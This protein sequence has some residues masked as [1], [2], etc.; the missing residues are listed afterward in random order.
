MFSSEELHSVAFL[1]GVG[2]AEKRFVSQPVGALLRPAWH[3][4]A[5]A[6]ATAIQVGG[7]SQYQDSVC[8]D[9]DIA[10]HDGPFSTSNSEDLVVYATLTE[11]AECPST[12][13]IMNDWESSLEDLER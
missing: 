3:C 1:G 10:E 8:R 13:K 2:A 7:G 9:I 11:S 6:V 12:D 5:P 4:S